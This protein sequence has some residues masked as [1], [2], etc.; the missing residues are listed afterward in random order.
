MNAPLRA[1]RAA[2]ILAILGLPSVA[3]AQV[4][5]SGEWAAVY[6]KQRDAAGWN[7]TPCRA[8]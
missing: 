8:G 3:A 1:V 2:A 5:F 4:D 6:I 7:P